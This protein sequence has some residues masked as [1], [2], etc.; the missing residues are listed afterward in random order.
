[1]DIDVLNFALNLEYLE[2]EFYSYGVYGRGMESFGVGVDGVG[3]QGNVIL[4]P[5]PRVS[6]ASKLVRQALTEV[7]IDERKHVAFLRAALGAAA[8]ARPT[9]D[10]RDSFTA[11]A[12]AAKLI[13]STQTFDPFASENN[14]L[15][16][17]FIFEDVGV[18]AYKGGARLINN[19]DFLEA[20]AGIL[21]VEAYHAG[22]VRLFLLQRGFANATLAISDV[23]DSLDGPTDLDQ[24]VVDK[25][26]K[27][28]LVPADRFSIVFSRTVQQVLNIVYGSASGR[29]GT[30][31]PHGVNSAAPSPTPTTTT[32]SRVTTPRSA[33][34][35]D[36]AR[37]PG[38]AGCR[39][40][41][42]Y[43]ATMRRTQTTRCVSCGQPI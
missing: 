38:A 7:A 12:R 25:N 18:T 27:A 35:V 24:G 19:K 20:A 36:C 1:M 17:S 29:P 4:P 11:L 42:L 32:R 40:T 28:N 26:G 9:I 31:F 43:R 5:T 3:K 34:S 13:N 15:L 37:T 33:T 8:V 2:G 22:V 6:F 30:F 21:G 41:A 39:T 23:R 10:L 16:A 14:F